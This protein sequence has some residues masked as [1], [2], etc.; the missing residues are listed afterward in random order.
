MLGIKGAYSADGNAIDGE[1]IQIRI[2]TAVDVTASW[3]KRLLNGLLITC[4]STQIGIIDVQIYWFQK[5]P[6]S[7]RIPKWSFDCCR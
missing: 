4:C 3:R 5:R 7:Y 6:L 2:D 1:G